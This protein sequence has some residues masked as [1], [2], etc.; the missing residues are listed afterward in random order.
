MNRPGVLPALLAALLFGASTPVAKVLLGT[1]DPWILAGLLYLGAGAVLAAVMLARR[2]GTEAPLRAA[3][4]PRLIAVVAVGGVLGPLLL[5]SGLARTDA[6]SA[7]LLLNVEGL[8]TMAIAWIVFGEGVDRR[9]LAGALAIVAGGAVLSWRGSASVDPGALLVIAACL[10]WAI[11]NNLSRGLTT[12]DP[13]ALAMAKGVV[14]GTVNLLAGGAAGG[15]LP[16]AATAAAAAAVGALGYGASLVLYLV[17]QRHLGAAR[18][19]A[20]FSLAPFAGAALAVALL[21]DP[22][23]PSLLAAAAL[24]GTGLWLHLAERHE[25]VHE[26]EPFDHEHRHVHDEHHRHEHAAG[27]PPG[28]PHSHPHHHGRLVHAHPHAPDLHHRHRHGRTV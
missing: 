5:M 24:M 4:L 2:G 16:G 23:T 1:V 20:Y 9:L 26:H 3:H 14:A 28:E 22:V 15:E 13:V 21:H 17:A 11:D 10:C 7:S 8:A 18:T 25:H 27:A 6:A 19:G 12:A